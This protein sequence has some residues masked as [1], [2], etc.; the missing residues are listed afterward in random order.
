MTKASCRGLLRNH[1]GE[2]IGGYY[3]I[4]AQLD[5]E[6]AIHLIMD[7]CEKYHGCFHI[8]RAIKETC[9]HPMKVSFNHL[10]RECNSSPH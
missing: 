6:E 4:E 9:A 7:G 3:D 2:F 1:Q 10:L 8:V 5:F